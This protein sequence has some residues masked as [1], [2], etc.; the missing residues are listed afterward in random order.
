MGLG[1]YQPWV[2]VPL[3]A[4][5]LVCSD[6]IFQIVSYQELM[7]LIVDKFLPLSWTRTGKVTVL[8]R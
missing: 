7:S 2:Y 5:F 8:Y 1:G 6:I 3:K 4:L